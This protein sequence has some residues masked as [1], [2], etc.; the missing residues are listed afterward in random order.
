[1]K[2]KEFF[3]TEIKPLQNPQIRNNTV[4]AGTRKTRESL[5][6]WWSAFRY[7][8]TPASFLPAILGG[9]VAWTQTGLMNQ[10][11]FFLTVLGVTLNHLALNMT[12]DYFDYHAA[13]DG[14]NDEKENPF[15]GG[16]GVLTGGAI[17]HAQI[18]R[19][20]T[21]FYGLTIGIGLYLCVVQTWWIM[22]FGLF[23]M[24]CSYFYTAPPVRYGYHGFGELS[25]L[26]N[27]SFTI[28]MGAYVVQTISFSGEAFIILLPLGLMMFAMIVINE[29]PDRSSDASAGKNNLVVIFGVKNAVWLYAI[30]LTLAYAIM[31]LAPLFGMASFWIYLTLL[32]LPWS[33][34][35]FIIMKKYSSEPARMTPANLLT[36]RVHNLT[37]ILLI[38]A[39]LIQGLQ[40][41]RAVQPVVF[42]VL[43][44][45]AFYLPAA[46]S[47]FFKKIPDRGQLETR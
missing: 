16:S 31:L 27:F 9:V 21:S 44:L 35:A 41:Q 24:A 25:Q 7:H 43:L 38:I 3:P 15:S 33:F 47:V 34:R 18:R 45:T 13:V 28:G 39:S 11:F 2:N 37:G 5:R 20:F 42:A 17:Q 14:K 19:V 10:W 46:V 32:T 29:I 1:M 40:N 30:A 8:F 26:I 4:C 36:I 23:G 12:D 6:V 22:A